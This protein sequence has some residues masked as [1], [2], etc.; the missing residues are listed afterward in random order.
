MKNRNISMPAFSLQ[1]AGEE[2]CLKGAIDLF[3]Q[4]GT[5]LPFHNPA[6]L[7]SLKQELPLAGIKTLY[8]YLPL[9]KQDICLYLATMRHLIS[10]G[11]DLSMETFDEVCRGTPALFLKEI[12]KQIPE[13]SLLLHDSA[14]TN[15]ILSEI[16]CAAGLSE[17]LGHRLGFEPEYMFFAAVYRSAGLLAA[18]RFYPDE[19]TAA[20]FSEKISFEKYFLQQTGLHPYAL[21]R[22]YWNEGEGKVISS[23][24]HSSRFM[25]A[26]DVLLKICHSVS[27]LYCAPEGSPRP[28]ITI[29]FEGTLS[30]LTREDVDRSIKEI[31]RLGNAYVRAH[32]R[33]FS[34]LTGRLLNTLHNYL[35]PRREQ[36]RIAEANQYIDYCAPEV[37]QQLIKLYRMLRP[38]MVKREC[39]ESLLREI[40]PSAGFPAGYI[41]FYQAEEERF[42]PR[43]II[44]NDRSRF[45]AFIEAK[46]SITHPVT[47]AFQCGYVIFESGIENPF[48][49][50]VL[51]KEEQNAVLFLECKNDAV[52]DL[53][54]VR[55]S[56]LAMRTALMDAFLFK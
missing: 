39:I 32:P 24:F 44:G 1:E 27:R 15:R 6:V 2:V 21:T 22:A 14:C 31:E 12:V 56:F 29:P 34:H 10:R 38:S 4:Y 26:E 19:F 17:T 11:Y 33:R 30:S 7:H 40:I 5:G 42:Y 37:R 28:S 9:L 35:A 18:A 49:A 20:C 50:Q 47:A 13:E 53:Q 8:E 16:V 41:A 48:F 43:L 52:H 46:G 55:N 51:G 36:T 54:Q 45:P 23:S 3:S 25:E